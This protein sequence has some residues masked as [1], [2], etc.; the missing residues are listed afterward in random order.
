MQSKNDRQIILS[1]YEKEILQEKQRKK[2]FFHR[3]ERRMGNFKEA[4]KLAQ[5]VIQLLCSCKESNK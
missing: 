1:I 3:C 4:E 5:Q 2:T